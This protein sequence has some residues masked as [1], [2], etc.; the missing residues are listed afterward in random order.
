MRIAHLIKGLGRGGAET[1]LPGL[2]RYGSPDTRVSVGYFLPWKDAL[3]EELEDAG[4]SVTCFE[5]RSNLS[6]LWSVRRVAAWLRRER[7]D[8]LHAHLPLAGVVG[9]LAGRWAGVPVVYT[10]HNLQERYHP[11]T[12]RLN[13]W[14]WRLQDRVVAVSGEVAQSIDR[15]LGARVPV[16]VVQ[17]GIPVDRFR[18]DPDAGRRMRRDLGIPEDSPV[19]GT[20]AVFRTQKRL[21]AW[22]RVAAEIRADD[23]SVRCLLVGD[24]P[25]RA[26]LET[27]A[28]EL[29]L[30]D[31][32]AWPGLRSDVRP[33]LA[34]MDVYLM[35]SAFEGLPL[36]LLEAMAMELP[37]VATA[38]GGIPEVVVE[39]ETGHLIDP[40]HPDRLAPPTA[41]LLTDAERRRRMGRAGRDR[42][43]SR[44]GMARMAREI[45]QIYRRVLARDGST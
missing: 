12:R 22:L 28:R 32:V 37:V 17:N 40:D 3:A 9:R 7:V 33:Y 15:H 4:A 27:A 20:V 35:S 6:I 5:T 10:E 11:A 41:A 16:D 18:P 25:L 24:G 42:V 39:G 2:L 8:L 38:V 14:T 19:L 21:D 26:E 29:G 31:A 45:E 44:F 30:T 43:E 23:P 1:L 36:A 13:A 34:A